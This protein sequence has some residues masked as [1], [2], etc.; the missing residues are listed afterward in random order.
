[1]HHFL[2]QLLTIFL[3]AS[4]YYPLR[5]S[6]LSEGKTARGSI[7]RPLRSRIACDLKI[8]VVIGING[9]LKAQCQVNAAGEVKHS[10]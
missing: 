4:V 10:I 5:T 8:L 3:V 1:M 6:Y 2:S 7:Y 9:N